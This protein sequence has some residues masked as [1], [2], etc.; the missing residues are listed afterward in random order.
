M[1]TGGFGDN[2]LKTPL[3]EPAERTMSCGNCDTACLLLWGLQKQ[4]GFGITKVAPVGEGALT[5]N[6]AANAQQPNNGFERMDF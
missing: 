2:D 5:T 4:H 6:A 1:N 3:H